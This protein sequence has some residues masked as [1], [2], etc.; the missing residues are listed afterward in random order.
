VSHRYTGAPE[1]YP[2]QLRDGRWRMCRRREVRPGERVA[3]VGSWSEA[4]THAGVSDRIVEVELHPTRNRWLYE[5]HLYEPG[6]PEPFATWLTDAEAGIYRDDQTGTL[7]TYEPVSPLVAAGWEQ[8]PP[9]RGKAALE[10]DRWQEASGWLATE[11]DRLATDARR[12]AGIAEGCTGRPPCADCQDQGACWQQAA[13][14]L[15]SLVES[16]TPPPPEPEPGVGW[17]QTAGG[18]RCWITHARAP[19]GEGERP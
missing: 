17:S 11:A 10:T 2:Q 3:I 6:A 19:E 8:L 4:S 18:W 13:G 16:L 5:A 7:Y 12:W 14:D 15:A 1:R 9:A